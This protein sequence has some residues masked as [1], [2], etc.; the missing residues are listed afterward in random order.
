MLFRSE[1][2]AGTIVTVKL[3]LKHVT[4]IIP[5]ESDSEINTY[6]NKNIYSKVLIFEDDITLGNMIKEFLNQKGFKVKLCSNTRDIIGF[7][8]IVSTFDIV[9]TD[10]QMVNITGT[11]I[12]EE[13]RKRD[14]DIPVWLMTANDEYSK[15]YI[16]S[17]GFNGLVKKPIQMS[18]LLKILSDESYNEELKKNRVDRLNTSENN[19]GKSLEDMFPGLMSMFGNDTNYIKELL[20]VFVKTSSK[21]IEYLEKHIEK[22][23]FF[24]AQKICHKIH[25]FLS[26]LDADYLSVNLRKMD[27][28]RG[29]DETSYPNWKD[30]LSDSV[31]MIK[32]FTENLRRDYL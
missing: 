23:D 9:F 3:P 18:L 17:K 4:D 27:S 2:G 21:E 32:E 5:E 26:Q 8:R 30:E 28:L 22:G 15:E 29:H 24:E 6:V 31:E 10:M 25:P 14:T 20:T 12:L 11:K 19:N 16:V 1:K 13:I 7:I